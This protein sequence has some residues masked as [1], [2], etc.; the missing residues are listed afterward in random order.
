MKIHH[1]INETSISRLTKPSSVDQWSWSVSQQINQSTSENDQSTGGLH[2]ST[3]NSSQS[4][5]TVLK[6][7]LSRLL[8]TW[9]GKV[10]NFKCQNASPT[11]LNGYILGEVYKRPNMLKFWKEETTR[12]RKAR[13]FTQSKIKSLQASKRREEE[14]SSFTHKIKRVF[15][16][17]KASP[18]RKIEVPGSYKSKQR[19]SIKSKLIFGDFF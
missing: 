15:S 11:T 3:R 4:T 18:Q 1:S 7:F 8:A 10:S 9:R 2:Q 5:T 12:K 13:A 16:F 19:V 17:T 6:N 14:E